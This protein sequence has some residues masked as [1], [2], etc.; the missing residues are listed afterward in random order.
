MDICIK[1]QYKTTVARIALPATLKLLETA[2]SVV[3]GL[4]SPW[5]FVLIDNQLETLN[6]N[7][8]LSL[9]TLREPKVVVFSGLTEPTPVQAA[10][11]RFMTSSS[12]VCPVCYERFSHPLV[13]KCGHICC[14]Q[15]WTSLLASKLECPICRTRTRLKMLREV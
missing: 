4:Q 9:S 2:A 1:L 14:E 10:R 6:P 11:N 13:S 15:C 8:F 7:N 3:F 5:L 12:D